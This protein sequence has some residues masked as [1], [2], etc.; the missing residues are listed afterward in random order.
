MDHTPNPRTKR[1]RRANAILAVLGDRPIAYHPALVK[2]LGG[3][4]E[5]V[6]VC[7][8]LYW[9]GKG[10]TPGGWIYKTRADLE[11]E[12]GL[13]RYNQET[14]RKNL[15]ALGVL[16]EQRRGV[17]GKMHYRLQF[18]RL[19]ELIEQAYPEPS[20]D[21]EA[22]NVET[23]QC[24][25]TALSQCGNTTN[26]NAGSPQ[27]I[28]ES[29]QET[30]SE[31][32]NT[33]ASAPDPSPAARHLAD[34]R[35][36]LGS[37]PLSVAAHC[38]R[39]RDQAGGRVW[40]VP[41]EAGGTDRAGGLMLSAW[42]TAKGVDPDVV[43]DK[44]K[45]KFQAGLS[46]LAATLDGITPEQATRAVEIVLDKE[47][48]EFAYY[49]YSDPAVEKFKRDW[50]DVALRLLSGQPGYLTARDPAQ[51]ATGIAAFK[52]VAQKRGLA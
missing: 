36:R 25:D 46:K 1:S 24:G 14:V 20:D 40:T 29:T 18:A 21:G 7:Q 43:P 47:N 38:Q 4:N 39:A 5:T 30:T 23:P 48:P 8:L 13:T 26:K 27:S 28:T 19:S 2:P 52:R 34:A 33:G 44:A 49:T 31:S 6:F 15:I 45:A 12:T 17:P 42:L 32:T 10:G 50:T 9:D 41:V 51:Q 35:S 11:E 37:D 22:H 3:I 16:E